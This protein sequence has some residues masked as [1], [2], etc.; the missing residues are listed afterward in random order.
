MYICRRIQHILLYWYLLYQKGLDESEKYG[1]TLYKFGIENVEK[2]IITEITYAFT[3]RNEG[4]IIKT[5]DEKYYYQNNFEFNELQELIIDESKILTLNEE[6]HITLKI[7]E[8]IQ[9]EIPEIENYDIYS[10]NQNGEH[11][12]NRYKEDIDII[13]SNE[14]LKIYTEENVYIYNKEKVTN[15]MVLDK[16]NNKKN[17]DNNTISILFITQ[18]QELYRIDFVNNDYKKLIKYNLNNII[19]IKKEYKDDMVS[20]YVKKENEYYKLNLNEEIIYKIK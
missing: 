2:I 12:K 9:E 10:E 18:S 15:F 7:G 13:L 11:K 20:L 4:V 6:E 3:T 8:D 1:F 17:Q 14:I 16:D 19:A 5:Y